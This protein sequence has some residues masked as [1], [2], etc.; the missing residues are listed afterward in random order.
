MRKKPRNIPV[1]KVP[2]VQQTQ[3]GQQTGQQPVDSPHIT[4]TNVNFLF[5][6]NS[7]GVNFGVSPAPDRPTDKLEVP[8]RP[9]STSRSPSLSRFEK[10][11]K[12]EPIEQL[13]DGQ[14][15]AY[16]FGVPGKFAVPSR[17]N[18]QRRQE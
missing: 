9:P 17:S 15:W 18:A 14:I 4:G 10:P 6:S 3:T 2:P 13:P 7:S 5:V 1:L 16:L 11:D 12:D 8:N